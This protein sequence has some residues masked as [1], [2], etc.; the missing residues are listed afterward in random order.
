VPLAIVDTTAALPLINDGKVRAIGVSSSKRS[1]SLKSVPSLAESGLPNLSMVVWIAFMA[2][3]GTPQA[4]LNKLNGEVQRNLK[5]AKFRALL[6]R[7]GVEPVENVGL[8]NF[9]EFIGR[10]IPRWRQIVKEAGLELR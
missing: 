4:V 2:P 5:D 6:A 8:A 1:S 3:K 7:L 10:E 9:N